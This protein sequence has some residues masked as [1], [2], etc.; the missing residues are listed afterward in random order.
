M[1]PK[2]S[3]LA[4]ATLLYGWR[5]R[6]RER[7][8]AE[9]DAPADAAARP[10]DGGDDGGDG[11]GRIVPAGSPDRRAELVVAGLLVLAALLAAGFVVAYAEL[12]PRHM[13]NWLLGVCIAGALASIALALA[14]L[15]RRLIVTEELEEE[16]PHEHPDEQAEIAQ[17]VR[18]SGSRLTRRRLLLGAGSLAGGALGLASLTPVLSLGPL[19]YTEPLERSPWRRGTRLVDDAGDPLLASAIERETFYT[20]FPEGADKEELAAPLVVVRLEAGE[21]RLPAGRAGW[22]PYGILAYSKICTHAGCAVA[23][24]RKP[25]FPVVDPKPALVCPC[26]YSTF[27]P[28]TGASVIFGPAGRPLPQLPLMIDAAGH[29]R[30]AGDFSARVGPAWWG[31]RESPKST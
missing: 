17:L 22:A 26:H 21:L 6:R 13:R 25:R 11:D 27:D 12:S 20:A 23:L 18:E 24:Y 9:R 30:A 8:E 3:A 19:W 7:R 2:R 4:L 28:A 5:R 14:V 1:R 16:Y 29:L 10:S 15:A 31:V